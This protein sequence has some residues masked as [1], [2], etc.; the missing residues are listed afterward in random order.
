[1]ARP[2]PTSDNL[3]SEQRRI[4]VTLS[5]AQI[6]GGIGNGA[7]LAAGALVLRD[8]TGSTA[9]AGTGTVMV[10]L[11]AAAMTMP[12]ANLAARA[13]RRTALSLGWLLGS[14]GAAFTV[15]GAQF[16]SLVLVALG[17]VGFGSSTAANLQSRFA[18]T[19]RA[20]PDH[21]ARSLSLVVWATTIGAVAGPNL[22]GPGAAIAENL[23]LVA[24]AGPFVLSA[25]S[26]ATGAIVIFMFL[27]PEPLRDRTNTQASRRNFR[28]AL[29]QIRGAARI[30][31]LTVGA[32][33]A[34]MV[35]VMSL[36]P[37]HMADHGLSLTII[38]FT[39]SLHIAGMYALSPV[40]GY[41]T[42]RLGPVLVIMLG[43]TVLLLSL[44][45]TALDAQNHNSVMIGLTLLGIGWS[46]SVIAGATLLTTSVD[47]EAKTLVQ[48]ASD[49]VMNLG[50]ASGGLIAGVVVA[51]LSFSALSW[52]AM[53]LVIVVLVLATRTRG[54]SPS[55]KKIGA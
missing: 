7:G 50:G 31:I 26:F 46:A 12:L 13:G 47:P 9:I 53:I 48:G 45:F 2:R 30:A 38:G 5:T 43:Q 40:F 34:V 17:L 42:D 29:P 35:A 1:M 3:V 15:F 44:L 54:T 16:N 51:T 21:I 49:L 10:T 33:H 23:G 6:I 11:G 22:V 18:A 55:K 36:T 28:A 19:D 52:I 37:V 41:L 4:L 8:V 25:F 39:I 14:L 20:E 24:L 32:S 27:R